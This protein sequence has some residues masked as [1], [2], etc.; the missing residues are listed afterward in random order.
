V[1]YAIPHNPVY[2]S[3]GQAKWARRGWR[4]GMTASMPPI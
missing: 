1:L 4:R 3:C 2:P